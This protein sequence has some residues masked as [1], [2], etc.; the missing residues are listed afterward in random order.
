MTVYV[1]SAR[2]PAKVGRLSARWSHLTA[3]TVAELDSFAD[4]LGLRRAWFQTCRR[5]QCYPCPHWHYDVV[6]AKRTEA[7]QLGAVEID[8]RRLGTLIGSRRG[9]RVLIASNG[10]AIVEPAPTE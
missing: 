4:Q 1:D 6:D 7:V 3:D 10:R 5:G 2:I 9:G 8:L